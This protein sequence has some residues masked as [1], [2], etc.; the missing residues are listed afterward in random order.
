[1]NDYIKFFLRLKNANF[2]NGRVI[3]L[4]ILSICFFGFSSFKLWG[5][6]DAES[7]IRGSIAMQNIFAVMGSAKVDQSILIKKVIYGSLL[8]ASIALLLPLAL[9]AISQ[10]ILVLGVTGLHQKATQGDPKAQYY[11]GV[12]Y[13]NG[14]GVDTDEIQG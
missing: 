4:L 3:I 11:L 6:F 12:K 5:V 1:M 7:Q 9:G 13:A 2:K 8:I 14:Q 10:A